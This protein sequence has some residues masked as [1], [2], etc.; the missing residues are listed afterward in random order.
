MTIFDSLTIRASVGITLLAAALFVCGSASADTRSDCIAACDAIAQTCMRTAH[1]TYEACKPAARTT[2]APKPPAE[3]FDCLSTAGRTC[4][5]THS[6]GALSR[7]LHDMLRRLRPRSCHAGRL[8][9]HIGR[10]CARR[11]RHR[12]SLQGLIVCGHAWASAIGPTRAVHEALH[13]QRP[14]ER[15]L[16]RLRSVTVSA[17]RAPRRAA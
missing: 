13:T 7:E 8:L 17:E 11:C 4:V 16:A 10:G 14:G 5:R 3:Q 2:C 6:K 15:V 9:V 12:Q 1:E